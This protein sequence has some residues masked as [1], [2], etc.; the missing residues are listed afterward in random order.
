MASRS[1][2]Q[3]RLGPSTGSGA[4]AAPFQHLGTA[5]GSNE[6]AVA[7]AGQPESWCPCASSGLA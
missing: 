2:A 5:T 3:G 1:G 6:L 4:A 7:R